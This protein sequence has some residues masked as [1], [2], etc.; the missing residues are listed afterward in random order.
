MRVEIWT[1]I[2]CP[3]CYIGKA[4]FEQALDAFPHKADVEVVHRSFELDPNAPKDVTGLVVPHIAEKYGISEAQAAGNEKGLGQQAG[5]LGLPYLTEGRD[6]GNSF[7]LHRLLH[8]ALDKGVQDAMIDALYRGNFAD[9]ESVFA[10][11]E[12]VVQ[13]AVS[14]GLDEAEVRGVL[15]DPEA[16]ADAVRADEQEAAALGATG[17]PFF[18]LDR[19]FGVSGAQPAEVFTQALTQAWDARSPLTVIE[20]GDA[21]GPDG[22]AV[23]Q[24]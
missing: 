21:C 9:E 5:E 15:A 20:S 17:V 12:H 2:N 16:Y 11:Q 3:F 6:Y 19:K 24:S 22:C 14:A 7:D 4:R 1:D 18:V 8:L 23:P 13:L 10:D